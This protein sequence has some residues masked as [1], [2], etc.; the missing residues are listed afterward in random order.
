MLTT[1]NVLHF[2]DVEGKETAEE[3]IVNGG[4]LTVMIRFSARGASLL[5]VINLLLEEGAQW[6]GR[7][8]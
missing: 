2:I 7:D 8:Y 3:L 1:L 6:R 4:S 5:L